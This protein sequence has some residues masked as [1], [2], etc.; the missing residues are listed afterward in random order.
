MG[1]IDLRKEDMRNGFIVV[2]KKG[3]NEKNFYSLI[4][5][6]LKIKFVDY[7]QGTIILSPKNDT[8]KTKR[9]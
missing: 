6:V 5:T 1:K 8:N 3:V 9:R 4:G 7:I 2:A